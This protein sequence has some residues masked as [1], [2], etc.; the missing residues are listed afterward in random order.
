[1]S[2]RQKSH[3]SRSALMP[4]KSQAL[5]VLDHVHFIQDDE[6]TLAV[7]SK[8]SEKIFRRVMLGWPGFSDG[9]TSVF[10]GLEI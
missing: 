4:C 1:M 7:S 5:M 10:W 2:I 6:G 8:D 3:R 9:G